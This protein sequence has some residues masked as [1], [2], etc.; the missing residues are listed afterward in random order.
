MQETL[1]YASAMDFHP[2]NVGG[3]LSPETVTETKTN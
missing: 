1:I 2:G 3:D